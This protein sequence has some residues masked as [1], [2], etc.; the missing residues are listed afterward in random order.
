[1]LLINVTSFFRDPAAWEVLRAEV[2]PSILERHGDASP[3]RVWSAGC[4]TG[5]EAYSVAMSL[6]ELLGP[7]EYR[8][9]VKIYGTDVDEEA[10]TRARAA[11][12]TAK[13][14]EGV[15]EDL[16][17]K[18][19]ERAERR[20]AFRADLRRT[21]IFGRNNLLQD[22]PIS[23]LDLLLCRN[24][25]MYFTAQSQARI[26]RQFHFALGDEGTLMLGR[27]EMM[28]SYRDAFKP[29][30]TKQRIFQRDGDA[31]TL[32]SRIASL[33]GEGKRQAR[34]PDDDRMSRDAALDIGPHAQVVVSRSGFLTFANLAARTLFSLSLDDLGS[35]F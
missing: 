27:S 34:S 12:Y 4:A 18:Y 23:R 22:A 30:D 1:M 26:L 28:L 7:K 14:L 19:F 8:D 25:L 21:V 17:T 31:T 6:A 2:L 29:I 15:P 10:L 24:T 9:R 13:E 33:A 3:I 16:R 35:P 11:V 32:Q 20:F 5:Q